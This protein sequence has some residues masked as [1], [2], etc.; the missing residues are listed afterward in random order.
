MSEGKRYGLDQLRRTGG[1]GT[2]DL[3]MISGF[4]M[5]NGTLNITMPMGTFREV[6]LVANE[7]RI[8]S[9][10]EGP[11]QIAQRQLI[12]D[13]AKKLALYILRGLLAGV[14]AKWTAQGRHI[15]DCLTD[16]LN[17]LGEGAY[18][19]LQP[20]TA[21][22]RNIKEGELEFED[23]PAGTILHLHKLQRLFIVDGQHRLR[24]RDG[25]R[26]AEHG[27]YERQVS[28]EG[29]VDW[30]HTGGDFRRD[31]GL[32][33]SPHRVRHCLYDRR[34]RPSR[35]GCREGAAAFPRPQRPGKKALG[36][37]GAFV[38]CREPSQQ[39]RV[40]PTCSRRPRPWTSGRGCWT[41]KV[42]DQ[43]RRRCN[44]PRRP[45]EHL[46]YSVPRCLQPVG[47]H[48]NGRNWRRTVRG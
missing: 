47:H 31:G 9:M 46:R 26:L 38:R 10:G 34:H 30:R 7:A 42:W 22:I 44:L 8:L 40:R 33:G 35:P 5:G 29:L 13:H 41:Q 28:K 2:V 25:P 20:F 1:R 12:P 17:E 18:Q 48:P 43:A 36:G 19:A 4:N 6:A 15:P 27:R 16:I 3:P 14:K 23:T 32:G 11:E 37:A 39:V 45:G 21:N 24:R